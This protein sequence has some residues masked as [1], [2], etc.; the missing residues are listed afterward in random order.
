MLV[1]A[2]MKNVDIN[3][4]PSVNNPGRHL[5]CT[6]QPQKDHS[7]ALNINLILI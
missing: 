2:I 6:P 1:L 5:I 7:R 3:N 4:N